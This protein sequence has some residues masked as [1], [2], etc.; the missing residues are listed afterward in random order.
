MFKTYILKLRAPRKK[1]MPYLNSWH[2][3][4][5]KSAK[6]ILANNRP[7]DAFKNFRKLR[8][9]SS[10][11]SSILNDK[12]GLS[13]PDLKCRLERWKEHFHEL[14]NRPSVYP[15]VSIDD[16]VGDSATTDSDASSIPEPTLAEIS[17]AIKRLKN[18][19]SPGICGIT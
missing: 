2:Q 3:I 18:N 17:S 10:K 12:N 14:L 9:D 13:L 7:H 15:A 1:L 11:P 19:K 8:S 6:N 16:D 4:Y 5:I